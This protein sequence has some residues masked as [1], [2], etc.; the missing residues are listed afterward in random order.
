M[1]LRDKE[2]DFAM[3]IVLQARK[4]VQPKARARISLMISLRKLFGVHLE[5]WM[6]IRNQILHL[7][8]V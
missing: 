3:C 4:I 7:P 8:V 1:S 5:Q 6:K 2:L